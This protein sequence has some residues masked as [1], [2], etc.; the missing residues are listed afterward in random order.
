MNI[1]FITNTLPPVVDGVGDYTLN[2][3]KEFAKYGHNVS[4]VC[5]RDDRIKTDYE[6]I[7]VFPIVEAWNKSAAAPVIRLIRERDIYI[8]SLQYVPHGYEPHG[9]PFG[10]IRFVKEIRKTQV[11]IFTFCHE[12]YWRYR[13][14]N[15]KFLAESL[16]M[17][18]ISKRILKYSDYVATSISHYAKMIKK[19]SGYVTPTI[20]IT[21]NIPVDNVD[22]KSKK[23]TVAPN[24]EFIVAFIGK[25]DL[26]V[27][28][29]ALRHLIDEGNNI[30]LLFIGKTNDVQS[31]ENKHCY[32]T[33]ILNIEELSN[34]VAAA[35]CMIMP[36]DN[37]TGCSLK[38]GSLAAALSFGIP[39]ITSKGIMT[40]DKLKDKENILF[41]DSTSVATYHDTI[42]TLIKNKA[43]AD[44]I[45][46]N[47]KVL[48]KML[49]WVETYYEYMKIINN[50]GNR[51]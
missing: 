26:T 21:S 34:Y 10:L 2:L 11:P 17:A 51:Q 27:V 13:G 28:S 46:K 4:I 35:D 23:A 31:I 40:D 15:V 1:L 25:R 18:F 37:I 43:F 29:D 9:L 41:V 44:K 49:T 47:A 24:K 8:V 32:H 42:E 45:S 5:K 16:L 3:A 50:N 33:G 19:L 7:K 30:K 14:F 48:G 22:A 20:P 36:E 39:V 6:D 12:V 38:S